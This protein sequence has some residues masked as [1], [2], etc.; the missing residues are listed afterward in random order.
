MNP[1]EIRKDFPQLKSGLIY[2]DSGATALKPISVI[3]AVEN[4]SENISANIGRG[5]YRPSYLATQAYEET[6]NLLLEFFNG[7]GEMVIT[8]NCTEAINIVA[9]GVE[10]NQGDNIVT[11]YLE[12]NSNY[13]PWFHLKN[14]GVELRVLKCRIDGTLDLK[15]LSELINSKTKLVAVTHASNVLGTIQPVADITAIAKKKGALVLID[16][17]QAAPHLIVDI[18]AIGC[19]FYAAS[20][21]KMLGPSGTG[22]LFINNQTRDRLRPMMLGGGTVTNVTLRDYTLVNDWERFEAGTPNI[23][24]GIGLGAAINYLK[25]INMGEV[26][27][28]EMELTGYLLDRLKEIP[29]ITIYGPEDLKKRTGVTS[30]SIKDIPAHRIAVILD[31]LGNIAIRSGFHCAFL[32][33]RE[34][35]MESRGTA[36]I[37]FY[38]Y[39]TKAE[40]D[41]CIKILKNIASYGSF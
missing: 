20:G 31:E 15:E 10:W 18:D 35:L 33:T 1:A 17:A 30:F 32:L 5:L 37:S 34:I 26:R 25:K 7:K 23:S 2:F 16:G 24:G 11:T 14:Q 28:H 40:I 38:I 6:H 4:Y 19:D 12:H 39:N 3:K 22:F 13:L 8:K 41:E 21:H 9:H 29:K 36:R 27:K